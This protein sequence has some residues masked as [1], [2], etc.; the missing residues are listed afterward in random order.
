[1]YHY[2][3]WLRIFEMEL[4]S[5]LVQQLFSKFL[6]DSNYEI[7]NLSEQIIAVEEQG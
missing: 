5:V 7:L 4:M 1:M 3:I 2:G 6:K